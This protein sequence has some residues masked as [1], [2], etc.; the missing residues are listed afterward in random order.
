LLGKGETQVL[1]HSS[2]G[3]TPQDRVFKKEKG[4]YPSVLGVDPE[5]GE[6]KGGGIVTQERYKK[7][8]KREISPC[9]FQFRRKPENKPTHKGRGLYIGEKRVG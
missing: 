1:V 9:F 8:K 6:R 4:N 3:A 2:S 5:G 7:G